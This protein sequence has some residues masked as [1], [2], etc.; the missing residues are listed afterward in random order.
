MKK[1]ENKI[2][3]KVCRY[4]FEPKTSG[5]IECPTCHTIY[6]D[7]TIKQITSTKMPKDFTSI[8]LGI[9]I[10]G[11]IIYAIYSLLTE[12]PIDYNGLVIILL[13]HPVILSLGNVIRDIWDI[14][15]QHKILVLMYY[16]WIKGVIKYYDSWSRFYFYSSLIAFIFGLILLIIGLTN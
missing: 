5:M 12:M 16:S 14:N 7:L 10:I 4:Q 6:S 1:V 13:I 15:Q 8:L 9:A 11:L 2:K 3:C